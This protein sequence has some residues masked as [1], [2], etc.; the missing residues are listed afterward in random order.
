MPH[1]RMGRAAKQNGA[2]RNLHNEFFNGLPRL[3]D[4]QAHGWLTK[5]G[6]KKD[7]GV[8]IYARGGGVVGDCDVPAKAGKK[9]SIVPQTSCWRFGRNL[10][11]GGVTAPRAS[12]SSA[13]PWQRRAFT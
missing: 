8:E 1:V 13:C 6:R 7:A 9:F 2:Y 10:A 5:R 3:P 11:G 4:A 12:H